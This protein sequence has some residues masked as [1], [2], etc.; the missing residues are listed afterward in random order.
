MGKIVGYRT[1]GWQ[2]N[3]AQM[4]GLSY[5]QLRPSWL[6]YESPLVHHAAE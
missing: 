5:T 1:V 2:V 6:L 3:E 4:S